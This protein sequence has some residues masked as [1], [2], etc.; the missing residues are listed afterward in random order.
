MYKNDPVFGKCA[1]GFDIDPEMLSKEKKT[2]AGEM[3][4]SCLP[5]FK[6]HSVG[7]N[8]LRKMT[9]L[10]IMANDTVC[11]NPQ[12]LPHTYSACKYHSLR[13]YLQI[14]EWK[15]KS[16]SVNVADYV[17]VGVKKPYPITCEN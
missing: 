11:V 2:A 17:W 12:S 9:F 6:Q 5:N 10:N 7:I 13:V 16:E 14:L 3:A 15:S 1:A 4:F 8:V